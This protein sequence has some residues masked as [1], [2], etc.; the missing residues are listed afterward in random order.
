MLHLFIKMKE[1]LFL[2]NR[3]DSVRKGSHEIDLKMDDP[4]SRDLFCCGVTVLC[5]IMGRERYP[6]R[7]RI[8]VVWDVLSIGLICVVQVC[9]H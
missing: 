4:E 1:K 2:L 3:R 6:S 5:L 8:S 9:I 7:A